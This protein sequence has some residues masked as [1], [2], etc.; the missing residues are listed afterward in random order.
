MCV[1]DVFDKGFGRDVKKELG[2]NGRVPLNVE[3]QPLSRAEHP[4]RTRTCT[5]TRGK[6]EEASKKVKRVR[7]EEQ[8]QQERREG[9]RSW[10]S[11]E[12]LSRFRRAPRPP[13]PALVARHAK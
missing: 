3:K 10:E 5:R 2:K 6:Q 11:V 13:L 4:L 7:T 1:G 8:K 9:R 12:G